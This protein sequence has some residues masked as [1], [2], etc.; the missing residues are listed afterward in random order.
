LSKKTFEAARDAEVILITQVKDNQEEL[1]KQLIHGTKIQKPVD[2]FESEVECAH[3]RIEHRLYEVFDAEKCLRKFPA[4]KEI[5]H[6]IRVCRRREIKGGKVS[7]EEVIYVCNTALSALDYA[8][9][10]RQ[11]WLIENEFNYV[12]DVSFLEDSSKRHVNPVIFSTCISFALNIIRKH[13]NFCAKTQNSV[14]GIL[15]ENS[16]SLEKTLKLISC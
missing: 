1:R 6:M 15:Y 12:K 7:Q 4:W 5:R 16:L 13:F 2:R 14:R 10:I 3:G 9:Y 8:K 11:H